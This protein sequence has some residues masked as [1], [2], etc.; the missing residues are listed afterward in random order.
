MPQILWQVLMFADDDMI[1]CVHVYMY[2]R[3][4]NW[5]NFFGIVAGRCQNMIGKRSTRSKH[6]NKN[7]NFWLV[8]VVYRNVTSNS[9]KYETNTNGVF[10]HI[11]EI[12]LLRHKLKYE[13]ICRLY[14]CKYANIQLLNIF[15]IF[16][17]V[18]L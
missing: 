8:D 17:C 10:G 15:Q 9:V 3:P 7:Q 14:V 13:S 18:A 11:K 2:V 4:P 6:K 16:A 12:N 1:L 5:E